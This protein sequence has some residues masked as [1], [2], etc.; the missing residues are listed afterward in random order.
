[1]PIKD[2][3]DVSKRIKEYYSGYKLG[4]KEGKE[5]AQEDIQNKAYKEGYWKGLMEGDRILRAIE[6]KPRPVVIMDKGKDVNTII[7]IP[8][9]QY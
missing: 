8:C 9:I 6:S 3:E 4:Y 5:A 7:S 2:L 1:M